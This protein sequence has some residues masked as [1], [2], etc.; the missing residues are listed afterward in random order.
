MPTPKPPLLF[1]RRMKPNTQRG[2]R[3]GSDDEVWD[4]RLG[5]FLFRLTE[6]AWRQP[7]PWRCEIFV[8]G[9]WGWARDGIRSRQ[10]A[11]RMF[12]QMRNRLV[13]SLTPE[14]R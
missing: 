1:G 5:D 3:G 4:L 6:F 14:G 11:L 9:I 7:D 10:Q 13:K 12:A 2:V 8:F